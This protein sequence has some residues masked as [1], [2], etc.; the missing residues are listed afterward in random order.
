MILENCK[1][2]SQTIGFV[3]PGHAEYV[4]DDGGEEGLEEQAALKLGCWGLDHTKCLHLHGIY[5]IIIMIFI[6]INHYQ[7]C[8]YPHQQN[9]QTYHHNPRYHHAPQH[10][11]H[12]HHDRHHAIAE[13]PSD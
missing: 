5:I 6:N 11:L 2:E 1:N 13:P 8:H 9:C 4:G 12:Y 7:E 3:A 10:V